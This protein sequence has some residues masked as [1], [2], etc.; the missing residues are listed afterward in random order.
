[1][2]KRA[3]MAEQGARI[4]HLFAPLQEIKREEEKLKKLHQMVDEEYQ[5]QK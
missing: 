3:A 4:K 1:M 5:K 2:D